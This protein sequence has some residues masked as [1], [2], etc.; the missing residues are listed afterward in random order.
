M[1][2]K[3]TRP[4]KGSTDTPTCP[5]ALGAAEG[6]LLRPGPPRCRPRNGTEQPPGLR[7]SPG[8]R[9]C[10]S[11]DRSSA[12]SFA[13]SLPPKPQGTAPSLRDSLSLHS[14][15]QNPKSTGHC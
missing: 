14:T 4:R 1:A 12:T 11:Q 8:R 3:G 2:H 5:Q 15:K 6:G 10:P 13:F 7:L 9:L